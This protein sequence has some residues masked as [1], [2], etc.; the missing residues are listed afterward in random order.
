[1][2][3]SARS[4]RVGKHRDSSLLSQSN[5]PSS[6]P[7]QKVNSG[8]ASSMIIA[9]LSRPVASFDTAWPYYLIASG[10]LRGR[11]ETGTVDYLRYSLTLSYQ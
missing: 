2:V 11:L 1:M 4:L 10:N 3:G 8:T 7:S 6:N 9:G 5:V